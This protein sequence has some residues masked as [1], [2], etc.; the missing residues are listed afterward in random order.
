MVSP[1]LGVLLETGSPSWLNLDS[2]TSWWHHSAGLYPSTLN[3][4]QDSPLYSWNNIK[5]HSL[6]FLCLLAVGHGTTHRPSMKHGEL[7]P[8]SLHVLTIIFH[9]DMAAVRITP[10][11][12]LWLSTTY[13]KKPYNSIHF[14]VFQAHLLSKLSGAF[15]SVYSR[16][17]QIT[18]SLSLEKTSSPTIKP[19]LSYRYALKKK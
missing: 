19:P 16:R 4:S 13:Q 7:Q 18:E 1:L 6:L 15:S 11:L 14:R 3:K 12:T 5:N 9:F 17:C 8:S 2:I 10:M